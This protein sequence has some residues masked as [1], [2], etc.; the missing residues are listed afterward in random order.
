[1]LDKRLISEG[2]K[3]AVV[4]GIATLS[5]ISTLYLLVTYFDIY[6]LYGTIIGFFVG[7]VVNYFISVNWV[8]S[9][10]R[11]RDNFTLEFGSYILIST[12]VLGFTVFAMWPLLIYL[13]IL[14]IPR[15]LL[16]FF[17]YILNFSLRKYFYIENIM[18]QKVTARAPLR[19][20]FAGGGTE[21]SP[22]VDDRGG[23]VL[24]AT[25]A[26]YAYCELEVSTDRVFYESLD[27]SLMNSDLDKSLM[28]KHFN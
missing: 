27:L 22:F 18:K 15:I 13:G 5:D 23:A 10:R 12:A 6:Y 21:L 25:I 9:S 26:M 14:F 2:L 19:L 16:I 20:S 28:I 11:F 8:F 1:M 17:T 3:Y 4:G 7:S 24:N